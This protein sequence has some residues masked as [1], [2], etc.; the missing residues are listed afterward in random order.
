[1]LKKPVLD[2]AIA[3]GA[4]SDYFFRTIIDI[5]VNSHAAEKFIKDQKDLD[6]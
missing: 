3:Q 6:N 1:M 5:I 4:Q 2:E